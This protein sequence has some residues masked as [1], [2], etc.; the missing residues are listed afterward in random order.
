[1]PVLCF[2]HGYGEAAPMDIRGALTLHGPLRQANSHKA[3]DCFIIAAPQ[4]PAKG[5]DWHKYPDAVRNIVIEVQNRYGGNRKQR[6]LTGFSY[7][8]NGVFDIALSM[9]GFWAALW[10]VDP[11]RVPST[12]PNVPIWLSMGE[13]SRGNK[14]LFVERLHLAP[15]TDD[16]VGDCIYL[17][18]DQDHVG[19]A[20]LAYRDDQVYAWLQTKHL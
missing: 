15:A 10:A 14:D 6:Y 4:L 11:T 13:R 1:M 8:G 17:D 7:G 19:T 2:L 9:P 5:D 20:T 12:N 16:E 3:T 18:S